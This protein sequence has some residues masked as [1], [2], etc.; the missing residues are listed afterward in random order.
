MPHSPRWHNDRLYV[1]NAGT[2]EFGWVDFGAD[3]AG[4]AAPQPAMGVFRPIAFCPGFLR[5]LAFAGGYA[6][7]GLSRPRYQRFEGLDL[8]RRLK[9]ADSDAW[10]GV[11][12]IDIETGHCTDWFR[13]DGDVGELYDV[14]LV[15]GFACPM[16]VSPHSPDAAALITVD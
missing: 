11:Q 8:D 6:F 3:S 2:G 4:A 5:G 1:L 14:E 15:A 9:E 7:V 12:V 13:I 16:A 10:C